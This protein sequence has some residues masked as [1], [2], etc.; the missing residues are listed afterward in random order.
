MKNVNVR[1]PGDGLAPGFSIR[2]R[3]DADSDDRPWNQVR[4]SGSRW[5]LDRRR[6]RGGVSIVNTVDDVQRQASQRRNSRG[7]D[8][9]RSLAATIRQRRPF[10]SFSVALSTRRQHPW[11]AVRQLVRLR[12]SSVTLRRTHTP[13]TSTSTTVATVVRHGTLSAQLLELSSNYTV[14]RLLTLIV[15]QN[16][17]DGPSP[18]RSLKYIY[19]PTQWLSR[20]N[21]HLILTRRHIAYAGTGT[22][23]RAPYSHKIICHRL[24]RYT[25]SLNKETNCESAVVT[26]NNT[27]SIRDQRS[28][29]IH[30]DGRPNDR[31]IDKRARPTVT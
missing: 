19:R 13:T 4:E 30:E 11:T 20:V 7:R 16:Y 14:S 17:Y 8:E 15:S 23:A 10:D 24:R 9:T 18:R 28:T 22:P 26:P 29:A 27:R 6:Q 3:L 25:T 5:W 31:P 2:P 1:E 12:N 21:S